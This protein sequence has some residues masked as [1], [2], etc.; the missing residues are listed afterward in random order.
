MNAGRALSVGVEWPRDEADHLPPQNAKAKNE[1]NC[2]ATYLYAFM[3]YRR[4][5]LPYLKI[6]S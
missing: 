3:V 1:W 6:K 2:T 5:A 4:A